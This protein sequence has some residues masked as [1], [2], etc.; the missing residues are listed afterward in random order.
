M[1]GFRF[2]LKTFGPGVIGRELRGVAEGK[3]GHRPQAV[4]LWFQG[5]KTWTG[6]ALAVAAVAA[7]SLGEVEIG[8][9]VL[10]VSSVA[11]S[12]GLI[13][14]AWRAPI[15]W[16][17]NLW[18]QFLRSNGAEVVTGLGF[19]AYQFTTCSPEVASMLARVHLTCGTAFAIVTALAAV[20]AWAIGEAR[21]TDGPDLRLQILQ[22]G[23][24]QR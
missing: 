9:A 8:A 15:S 6:V 24:A 3:Y 18:W 20:V 11:I 21:L 7:L 1:L 17:T 19:L 10:A 2:L 22:R 4:Y 14:K 16:E 13:D 12:A 23:E 5:K